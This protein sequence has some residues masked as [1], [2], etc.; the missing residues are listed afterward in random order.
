MKIRTGYPFYGQDVGVL[1]FSTVTPR[2][3]GDA[4]NAGSFRYPVRY[5]VVKGGFADLIEGGEE[6]KRNLL[7]ACMNLKEAGIKAIVGDCGMMSLY[8]T[9]LAEQCGLPVVASSLCQ[10]PM[11]WQM[12][13][14]TGTIGILTGHDELLGRQ[15]LLSSG[16][17]EDIKIK[18]QGLQH[19]PHFNE[20]V[21]QGGLN[22]DVD[23]MRGDIFNA[24]RKLVDSTPDLKAIV[25]ECSNI[26]T[27]SREIAEEFGIPVF[28]VMSASN[29]LHYSVCPDIYL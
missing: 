23:R 22:I 24:V 17:R 21:I 8:Q 28:D 14:A 11:I 12:I 15:H 7:E 10:I 27:Y 18:L 19:E 20:I 3:V 5:E 29:L 16:W 25:F 13:G 2:V 4:G 6:I 1:V 9:Y 26:S